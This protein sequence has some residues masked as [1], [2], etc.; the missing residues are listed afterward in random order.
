MMGV[1]SLPK[2]VTRQ[3]RGCDLNPGPS[4]PESS[5]L[6]T[7][8]PSHPN[9]VGRAYISSTRQVLVSVSKTSYSW[10]RR[11]QWRSRSITSSSWAASRR[12]R[13]SLV[14]MNLAANSRP[15]DRSRHRL[16]SPNRPLPNNQPHSQGCS[17]AGMRGDGCL[18]Y[19]SPSPR[20]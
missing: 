1:N 19:T 17:G 12:S 13:W 18:L 5:S 6:T 3:R 20:D 8:L 14:A 9:S 7:R 11:R 16:T 4:A 15:L 2:I 10:T